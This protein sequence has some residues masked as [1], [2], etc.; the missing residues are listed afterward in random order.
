MSTLKTPQSFSTKISYKIYKA[1]LTAWTSV[2]SVKK[3]SWTRVIALNMPDSAEEE[4]IRGKIFESLG[5]ELAGEEGYNKLLDWLD[6]HYKQ[7]IDVM[8]IDRIK[9]FMKYIKRPDMSITEFLAGFD[10]AYNTAVKNGLDK[11]P[12]AY[13]MYM[14]IEN[15]DLLEQEILEIHSESLPSALI[16]CMTTILRIDSM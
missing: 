4:D 2:T 3:E 13:L 9:Q 8:M 6:K 10:T 16:L 7:D 11:F 12:Q 5:D 14:I 15:A 1:E